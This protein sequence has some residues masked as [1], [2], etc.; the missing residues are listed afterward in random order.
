M[1]LGD[2]TVP[3]VAFDARL[4]ASNLF[5]DAFGELSLT[6]WHNVL[7]RSLANPHVDGVDFPTSPP[8]ETQN[9]LHGHSGEA[10]LA[11]S[12][13]FYRFACDHGIAG[14]TSPG[15]KTGWMMDYGAG[16][17]RILRPF[18]RDFPLRNIIGYEPSGQFCAV[19][20]GHNP[21]VSFINGGYSPDGFLPTNRFNLIVGWSIYSHIS[22]ALVVEWLKETARILVVGG[23]AMY[24]TWGMRFLERLKNEEQ[25][26]RDGGDIHWY[27]KVC[28]TGSGDLN[29]RIKEF[30]QGKFVWFKTLDNDIY[31]ETF[32][33]KAVLESMISTHSIPLTID[34][35]DDQTLAQDVFIVRRIN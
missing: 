26:L 35:F 18:I 17:G 16:W 10:S 14:P 9:R 29:E 4:D 32:M 34:V 31:G 12:F 19:A 24:T 23:S 7:V 1:K 27:S 2:L 30:S 21:F 5:Q 11:E 15:Y 13:S 3:D 6:D 8:N 20:R 25:I 33:S 22:E 28:L